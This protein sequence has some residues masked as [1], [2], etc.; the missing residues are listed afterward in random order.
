[1]SANYKRGNQFTV[2]FVGWSDVKAIAPLTSWPGANSKAVIPLVRCSMLRYLRLLLRAEEIAWECV[3][4]DNPELFAEYMAM[5][6]HWL[7]CYNAARPLN[8]PTN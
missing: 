8:R 1:M 5:R 3:Q 2:L 4:N 6:K 7:H